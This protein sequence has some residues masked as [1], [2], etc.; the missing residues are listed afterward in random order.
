MKV[1]PREAG[2]IYHIHTYLVKLCLS[3]DK[4]VFPLVV[5]FLAFI[6]PNLLSACWFPCAMLSSKDA[7]EMWYLLCK[8]QMIRR[9]ENN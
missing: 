2:H 1:G 7:E 8:V 9:A 4:T 6:P 3:C 5:A